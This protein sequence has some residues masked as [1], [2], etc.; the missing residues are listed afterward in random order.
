MTA[1]TALTPVALSRDTGN[2]LGAGTTPDAVNGNTVAAP[3]PFKL[4]LLVLNGDSAS[5]TVTVRATGNGVTAAGAAQVNPAPYSTVFTQS[6]L[7]DLVVTVG[8]GAYALIGPLTSDRFAQSDGSLSVDY[9]ASTS[10]KVWAIQEPL[11]IPS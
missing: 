11:V 10:V 4:K 8:A 5:H 3:G 6:T 7:G 2:A 9:S 1:R